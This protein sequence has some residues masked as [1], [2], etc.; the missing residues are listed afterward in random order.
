LVHYHIAKQPVPPHKLNAAIP[1]PVSEIILKLM[2]KNSED[3]YQSAGGITVDLERCVE[4]LETVGRIEPFPLGLQDISNQFQIPQKLYG[5]EV[6]TEAL[7]AA[8]ERIASREE[9]EIGRGED[10]ES[11]NVP[12][13]LPLRV[14]ASSSPRVSA[15]MMLVSG[16]A[17]VGKSALVQELY[18]PITAKRGYFISGK[19]DQFQR[20]IPYSAIANALQKLVRQLLN[21]PEE[22][23]QQ[24]RSRLL[25]ALGSIGQLIADVIPE[26]ELIIGKQ[27]PVTEVG[28]TEAQNRFNRVFQQFIRVFCSVEHPLVIFLDDLQWIDSATLKLIELMLLDEQTQALFLIGTYR[29]NEVTSVHPLALSLENLRKQG[30]VPQK[31]VLAPLTLEP[32]NQLIAETLHQNV[33]TVATLTK[34]V[35]HK[36][37]GNP[38]FVGE[39]LRSLYSDNLL[40]FKPEQ[41][42]W[43]WNIAQIEAQNITDNVVD[44]LLS[45]LRNLP[46]STQRV[47]QLAACVGA[48]FDLATLTI[49]VK[50]SPQT[51]FQN[52]LVAIQA[53]LV[54]PIS[55]LDENLLVQEYKFLHDRVQQA[56]YALID[57]AQKQVVHLQIGR[58]LLGKILLERRSNRL[59]ETVDHLNHGIEL[60]TNQVERD[61]F[62]KLNL[63]AGQ[64]AKAAIAYGTAR[65]YFAKGRA[66]LAKSSWQTNYDLTLDL[67]LE[68]TEVAYLCGEFEQ[69]EH[70]AE[71]VLRYVKTILDS[72]PVYRVKIQAD[73]AQNQPLQAVD[74]G[75]Q[76]LQQLGISF[77]KQSSHPDIRTELDIVTSLLDEKTIEDLSRLPNMT[78]PEKLAAMQILSDITIAAKFATPNLFLL[79]TSKQVNLSILYGNASVSPFSYTIFGLI[80]CSLVGDIES[81]YQFGQ[82]ALRLLSQPNTHSLKAR[83]LFMAYEHVLHW[84][85]HLKESLE[86]LLEIYQIGLETGDLEFAAYCA[87]CYCFQLYV[88][89]KELA[90]VEYAMTTYN[91]A[92]SQIKQKTALTWNQTFQQAIANLMGYSVNPIHLIGRFYN[93]ADGLPKHEVA[94]DGTAIFNASFNKLYLCYLFSEYAQAIENSDVAEPYF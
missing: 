44:L 49:V 25:E 16:Y 68:T 37:E 53:G 8:F 50:Q 7:L 67:Y 11:N 87:H 56:A 72:I 17:G 65:N 23:L 69:V 27:L 94:N 91:E 55:E 71:I 15:E 33:G 89:G 46:E 13:S 83:T 59:F 78:E 41:R 47:L 24:W 18:K 64:K 88:V 93:E 21:E 22:K 60:V 45:K 77:L 30:I 62:A 76:I 74:T 20:D 6:E 85:E 81:G 19:F 42:S 3:R 28:A 70:W 2:A 80:L 82:L 38:F 36:T 39:F 58:N 10:T 61:E 14:P 34:L 4:Q 75:L 57:E 12:A 31:I 32:L 51:V 43:Q 73:I 9:V 84:K 79:I 63:L 92:I 29:D 5:R 86:P 1:Q 48:E 54:Q 90:E 40:S 26:V 66:W 52:L 35:L